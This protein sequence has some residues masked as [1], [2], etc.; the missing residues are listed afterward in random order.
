MT[1]KRKA[2]PVATG[3]A[4]NNAHIER[5]HSIRARLKAAIVRLALLGLL[6]VRLADST[7]VA[8]P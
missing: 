2:V 6:P 3:T 4:S 7:R 8:A 5:N 1:P